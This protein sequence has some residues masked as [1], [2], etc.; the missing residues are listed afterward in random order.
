MT[1]TQVAVRGEI[2]KNNM[3]NKPLV[4]VVIPVF[5]GAS[6]LEEAVSS[7]F[8]SSYRNIE[9]LLIDDGS[10]DKSK[11]LCAKLEK[12]YSRVK[13]Y[14]FPKNKGLGR[15]LNFAID[16]AKGEYICRLNQDD[17]ML[18]HRI[19]T[20]V[21]YLLEHTD[22]VAL[23]SSIRLFDEKGRTQ[24]VHFLARDA[25]IKRVW[26]IVSPFADPSVMYRKNVA[27]QVGGYKQEFW[28]G[29]DTHLW[30]RMG[31][32]GKLA[33]IDKPLVEVRYHAK[34]ASVKHFK[35]LTVITYKLHRWMHNEVQKAP[36]AVQMFWVF[37]LVAGLTLSPNLNWDIYRILKKIIYAA[38]QVMRFLRSIGKTLASSRKANRHLKYA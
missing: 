34:A 21:E 1:A 29:D 9:V 5:N 27:K 4:S 23:G 37:Q 18:P 35:K 2:M 8:K 31:Q 15:V 24:I 16:N 13:F 28:P 38:T 30:I 17:I 19:R 32:A 6:F 33:N 3:N 10:T 20:Q 11:E 7:V 26:H 12:K 36:I 14:S 25:Q 22:V